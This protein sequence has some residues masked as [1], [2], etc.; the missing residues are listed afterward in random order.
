[1]IYRLGSRFFNQDVD[2][3]QK[4]TNNFD[5]GNSISGNVNFTLTNAI[6]K[7]LLTS[8]TY[9]VFERLDGVVSGYYER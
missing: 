8:T 1:M 2:I 3:I 6:V 4:Q 5:T 9:F 7:L